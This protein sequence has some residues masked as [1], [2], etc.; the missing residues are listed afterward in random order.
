MARD[1]MV[2][3]PAGALSDLVDLSRTAEDHIRAA[4]SGSHACSSALAD[5]LHGAVDHVLVSVHAPA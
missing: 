5:A 4:P 3:V 1:R 2:E